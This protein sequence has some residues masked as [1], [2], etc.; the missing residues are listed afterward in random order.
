MRLFHQKYLVLLICVFALAVAAAGGSILSTDWR[1]AHRSHSVELPPV[2]WLAYNAELFLAE[3][4]RK[5]FPNYEVGLPQVRLYVPEQ[6]QKALLSDIPASTKRWRNGFKLNDEGDL[7]KV[8]VRHRGDNPENWM[9]GR[10]SW[11]VKARKKDITEGVRTYDYISA[12]GIPWDEFIAFLLAERMGLIVPRVRLVEL[13][14]NDKSSGIILEKERLDESFLRNAGLM[15]IN[16]YKGEQ[17][18][19]E[20]KIGVDDSLFNNPGLW[21]KQANFNQ[22]AEDDFSDLGRLINSIRRADSDVQDQQLLFETLPLDVWAKHG[23]FGI[24]GSTLHSSWIH[25]QR[26]AIDPWSGHAIPIPHDLAKIAPDIGQWDESSN[27]VTRQLNMQPAF[28]LAKYQELY[29]QMANEKALSAVAKIMRTLTGP[30]EISM[31]RNIHVL[32]DVYHHNLDRQLLSPAFAASKLTNYLVAL[33]EKEKVL[34][35]ELSRAPEVEW[36]ASESIIYLS[37]GGELPAG[38]LFID[39][40]AESQAPLYV[41]VD[42]DG[43]SVASTS[44][45]EIPV[46]YIDGQLV[47]DAVWFAERIAASVVANAREVNPQNLM[48]RKTQF[49]LIFP[50]A[51]HVQ[52][53]WAENPITFEKME[54]PEGV[55]E[56]ALPSLRNRPLLPSGDIESLVWSGTIWVDEDLVIRQPV[57]VAPGTSV[58]MSPGASLVFRNKLEIMGTP[59]QP[60]N[61]SPT[62]AGKPWGAFALI[63]PKAAGSVI[64]HLNVRGGSGD[65]VDGLRFVGML[66]IH[67]SSKIDLDNVHLRS[68]FVHDDMLHLVYVSNLRMTN[69]SFTD[70]RFDGLDVDLSSDVYIDSVTIDRAG[71]DAIDLMGSDVTIARSKL[72]NSGDKGISVG[73]GSRA[74]I[75]DTRL[76]G[77]AI[78]IESKDG[79]EAQLLHVDL[80][81]NAIQVSAYNKNWRYGRGGHVDIRKSTLSGVEARFSIEKG[82]SLYIQDSIAI[83]QLPFMKRI[84]IGP[85]VRTNLHDRQVHADYGDDIMAGFETL[86]HQPDAHT[87]GISPSK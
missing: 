14:I 9:Y 84:T 15:P 48:I 37:I 12:Q 1:V 17:F 51:L 19:L 54:L 70:A 72:L 10:K 83:P 87:I 59:S 80:N 25:N 41:T 65:D 13:F 24:V 52:A 77:N 16:L 68:N 81:A 57:V 11:R 18:N 42:M 22:R 61:I 44:D 6:A 75:V 74:L 38:R 40:I 62:D 32:Q 3:T 67:N 76:E 53:V 85:N 29:H 82:S 21:S 63:G 43:D 20:A 49:R 47:I 64:R 86:A 31:A 79:S 56:G 8:K 50:E 7:K 66:S 78:G 30:I 39:G 27:D 28:L 36:R 58:L 46:T 69:S 23:A 55:A 33:E 73:E 4:K 45:I 2:N 34:I 35:R 71:N 60:V 5:L 26:I